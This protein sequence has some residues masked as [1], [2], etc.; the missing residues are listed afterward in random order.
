MYICLIG[1]SSSLAYEDRVH[2]DINTSI[3]SSWVESDIA[4]QS[5]NGRL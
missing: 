3:L 4:R 1:V 5:E 2:E